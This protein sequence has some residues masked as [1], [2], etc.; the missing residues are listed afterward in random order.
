[1]NT[2][3]FALLTI[4]ALGIF[5]LGLIGH[6]ILEAPRPPWM[7]QF[8]AG[9]MLLIA[10]CVIALLACDGIFALLANRAFYLPTTNNQ[11]S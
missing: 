4:F 2:A 9:L 10:A 1:M 5:G 8:A 6:A 7:V 3:Q 11:L